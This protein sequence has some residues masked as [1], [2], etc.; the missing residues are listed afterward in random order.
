MVQTAERINVKGLLIEK[1]A[2]ES[3][4]D[5]LLGISLNDW[6]KM[7]DALEVLKNDPTPGNPYNHMLL[8]MHTLFPDRFNLPKIGRDPKS[9]ALLSAYTS[10]LLKRDF[11]GY[12]CE[13]TPMKL[14]FRY[15]ED[16]SI[17]GIRELGDLEKR[18]K[19]KI[20]DIEDDRATPGEWQVGISEELHALRVMYP[21]YFSDNIQ[22]RNILRTR[23]IECF[24]RFPGNVLDRL[25]FGANIKLLFPDAASELNLDEK[26]LELF[27]LFLTTYRTEWPLFARIAFCLKILLA[28]KAQ[29]S[30][31]GL[32]LTM[33]SKPDLKIETVKLPEIRRF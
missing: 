15:A 14:L 2:S 5:P 9:Y 31:R 13:A 10:P 25:R 32:E 11:I 7:E 3:M 30:D 6:T 27:K 17:L 20:S 8:H 4:L 16:L 21:K 22:N 33:P 12:I 19:S 24:N 23:L 28:Q 29:V 1:A 18:I 26:S